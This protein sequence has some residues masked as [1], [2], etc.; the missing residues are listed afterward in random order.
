VRGL[1]RSDSASAG[2]RAAQALA[3]TALTDGWFEGPVDDQAVK[4]KR[5]I[6]AIDGI[7]CRIIRV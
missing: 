6:D 2:E 4:L 3:C 1:H 7:R 5:S